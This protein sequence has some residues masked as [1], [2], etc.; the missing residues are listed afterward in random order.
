MMAFRKHWKLINF[1]R[2]GP[3][4]NAL[5][6]ACEC[7]CRR[8]GILSTSKHS[9]F[10]EGRIPMLTSDLFATDRMRDIIGGKRAEEALRDDEQR[11]RTL[12]NLAPVAVYSCDVSGVNQDYNNRAA[13]L[14]G[15]KTG[16]W[17]HR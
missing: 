1:E 6:G 16:T 12:F 2:N 7:D 4:W 17:G 9:E 11:Y 8:T 14:W 13:E 15:R 10:K 3:R 5:M